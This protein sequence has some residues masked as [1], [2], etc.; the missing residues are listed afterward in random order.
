M[1]QEDKRNATLQLLLDTTRTLV[2]E[3]GSANTTL[4]DIM[5]R[6]GLSKGAIFHYVKSKD[7]LFALLLQDRLEMINERFYK[8]IDEGE[9]SF[10]GPFHEIVSGLEQLIDPQEVTNDVFMYLVSKNELPIIQETV[11]RFYDQSVLLAKRWIDSGKQHGVIPS[12]VDSSKNAELFTLLSLGFRIRSHISS[13]YKQFSI[14]D[15]V[16]LMVERLQSQ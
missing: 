15:F 12:S 1:K 8:V 6:S 5:E 9:R 2:V 3:K 11:S 13:D 14:E 4:Y 16:Q 7:E 10:E